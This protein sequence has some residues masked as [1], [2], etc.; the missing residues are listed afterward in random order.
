MKTLALAT[1]NS[2]E[3]LRDKL[4]LA[5]GIGF[6]VILLLLLSAIQSN[7]PVELF[8]I[9]QLTPGIAVFGLSF[10][11]L[12]SGMLIAKDRTSSL[13][14]RL[15][16]SPLMSSNFIFGYTLPLLPM[17][18]L[19]VGVCFA[20]AFFLG[21]TISLNVLLAVI[22][23]VPAAILFIAIGLLCG[24][25]FTDKQVGGVC[26]ALLTNLSAWLSGTWFDLALVGGPFKKI[27]E[28]LPFAH[29][30]DAGR[31]AISGDYHHIFPHLWW[32]IGYAVIV[33][34]IAIIVFTRKMSSD[35]T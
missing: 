16:T 35:N 8:V 13:M 30:V 4:N 29:A 18:I 20:V 11:S 12:F 28:L 26:G 5:F 2:K 25:L 10:I 27:A 31:A 33:M 7:V 17:A 22:V 23:L 15:F 6:P 9:E 34:S 14:L 21:L 24:S 32:V 3:I 19:Q 1:R